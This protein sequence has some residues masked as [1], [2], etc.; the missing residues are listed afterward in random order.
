VEFAVSALES[1][2]PSATPALQVNLP[3]SE[4]DGNA[5]KRTLNLFGV[6]ETMLSMIPGRLDADGHSTPL[7]NPRNAAYRPDSENA[8]GKTPE[9]LEAE[10]IARRKE[11]GLTRQNGAVPVAQD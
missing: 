6:V 11:L 8:E 3:P 10:A 5:E 9:Q 2:E 7:E 4:A 1:C